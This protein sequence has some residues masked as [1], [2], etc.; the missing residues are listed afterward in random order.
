MKL[1][2]DLDIVIGPVLN[3]LCQYKQTKLFKEKTPLFVVSRNMVT[4]I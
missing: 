2:D 3:T 1:T 4:A